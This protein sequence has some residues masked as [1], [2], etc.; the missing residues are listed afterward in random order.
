MESKNSNKLIYSISG[1]ILPQ[2]LD[3]AVLK[4]IPKS[5]ENL[6]A[7][8][9]NG[10]EFYSPLYEP[11]NRSL[12]FVTTSSTPSP[13]FITQ[14][15][16]KI[17][18]L[19]QQQQTVTN[20]QQ[21]TATNQQQQIMTQ[22]QKSIANYQTPLSKS[23]LSKSPFA[24]SPFA[25]SPFAKS[26]IS[27]N[28]QNLSI[29][30]S[31]N[32]NQNSSDTNQ[33]EYQ[34]NTRKRDSHDISQ[35]ENQG[36]NKN[37][38]QNINKDNLD[39]L[40]YI[41]KSSSD[42]TSYKTFVSLGDDIKIIGNKNQSQEISQ[43][44]FIDG[45][46]DKKIY[47]TQNVYN[48]PKQQYIQ[49]SYDSKKNGH[50]TTL[51]GSSYTTP[52]FMPSNK[53]SSQINE[54]IFAPATQNY[55][56]LNVIIKLENGDYINDYVSKRVSFSK[57]VSKALKNITNNA[58]ITLIAISEGSILINFQA[59]FNNDKDC[60]NI[61]TILKTN[62]NKLFSSE[63]SLKKYK[64]IVM[65]L[66][67]IYNGKKIT[68]LKVTPPQQ[69]S[70]AATKA[71]QEYIN[72][73]IQNYATPGVSSAIHSLLGPSSAPS[74][75]YSQVPPKE[76]TLQLS[77]SVSKNTPVPYHAPSYSPIHAPSYSPTNVAGHPALHPAG[78]PAFR[79]AGH[80]APSQITGTP[81]SSPTN[82]PA[83]T[84]SQLA[85]TPSQLA[86]A[87]YNS[88]TN[89]SAITPAQ[90]AGAPYSS[91]TNAP[92]QITG[93]PYRSPMN[94]P[95]QIAS[96]PY[97]S[98]TN[99][100]SQL[101]GAP[102]HSP[103]ALI[104]NSQIGKKGFVVG[105]SDT[106]G[107]SKV[108]SL[109]SSWYYTWGPTPITPSPP[110]LLFTPMIWN[111]DKTPNVSSVINSFKT[112]NIPGQENILLTY[113]EPDGINA[114]A[115]GN[116]LVSQAVQYW[117]QIVATNRRL[118][119]PVMYGS[120][121]NVT[122]DA[123][124]QGKNIN[125]MPQPTGITL[126]NGTITI[127]I[128]N[129]GTNM[130]TLNP[131]IW[132]DNFL[133]QVS[134]DYQ[135]NP[136]NYTVRGPFPDFIC[137][138][139]YGNP[140]ASAFLDYLQAVYNKYHLPLW[141]TEYSVADWNATWNSTPAPGSTQHTTGF[142]WSIPTATNIQTNATAQFMAQT[143][144]GMNAMPFVE[145]YSW[146]ERYLLSPPGTLPSPSTTPPGLQLSVESSTNINY[147]NQSALFNSYVHFPT[148]LP[149][150]TPLGN[151]YAS[152]S[153]TNN[154]SPG[155]YSSPASSPVNSLVIA[156]QI[157]GNYDDYMNNQ[158]GT[159]N[160]ETI[161]SLAE[162][163][164]NSQISINNITKGSIILHVEAKFPNIDNSKPADINDTNS[165]FGKSVKNITKN[166]HKLFAKHKK[167]KNKTI[168]IK[169]IVHHHKGKRAD[170]NHLVSYNSPSAYSAPS[171]YNAPS[172]SPP[173]SINF[174]IFN[175]L[176]KTAPAP[177]RS[178]V[179]APAPAPMRA[180]ASAPLRS[181]VKAPA[182]APFR[183]PMYA[184]A[185]APLRSPVKAPAPAPFRS[186][187]YAPAPAPFR[188]PVRAPAP[189]PL[190]SPVK[191]PAPA[192]FRSPMY[193]PAPAPLRSPVKAP[194]TILKK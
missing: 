103:S 40:N 67:Q 116:M 133:I 87:P 33:N 174:S 100:P 109:N 22:Q 35:N 17:E 185:P 146:K 171:L 69:E 25:K 173:L 92:S 189:A 128:S 130:V 3:N 18:A 29:K 45:T 192:P 147:M 95:S 19:N 1:N 12:N 91:P 193:A 150:L 163:L 121:T 106:V 164:P 182:P 117:P 47:I 62:P 71:A 104:N 2:F 144:A 155:I 4:E 61:I 143:V 65:N 6:Y 26:P 76:P 153:I 99:A 180:P 90:I 165:D 110:G 120:L 27:A 9:P 156:I 161:N 122:S 140:I 124:G 34:S 126:N 59:D 82:A 141:I 159:D 139:W 191:A 16:I 127:N 112:L 48:L 169:H 36:F 60:V 32:R 98:P 187:M 14:Q 194:S 157:D 168:K 188:S 5:S 57:T 175:T 70:V 166:S 114:S 64:I 42:D 54:P 142:D 85:G 102:Y 41:L 89:A 113:N 21:Q 151:L 184:P 135:K 101:A 75:I 11:V 93:T 148:T 123:P 149:P 160:A 118:G 108:N 49:N 72:K 37:S 15:P 43:S 23:P 181:P 136:G 162:F 31:H 10:D 158:T 88:P 38:K 44:S 81:Y 24:K 78:H 66:V 96:T 77:Q 79:P 145:R 8:D 58:K 80:P 52:L 105:N 51:D 97:R 178:P 190:R 68:L 50:L 46:D 176:F 177:F 7:S 138:H 134:Q 129:T 131:A 73:N 137:I 83:I 55:P 20:Q 132:L 167:F 74:K 86:G 53:D 172:P 107:G 28:A 152:L 94:A 63:A 119:S 179:K 170:L 13:R 30:T 183:S 186:P 125:N 39:A 154:I 56:S 111:I 115:Q 84:P